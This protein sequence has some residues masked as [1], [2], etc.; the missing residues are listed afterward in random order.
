MEDQAFRKYLK[1]SFDKHSRRTIEQDEW[2]KL[3]S[4]IFFHTGAYDDLNSFTGLEEK[5]LGL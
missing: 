4:Q 5:I 1:D 3:E 2:Q